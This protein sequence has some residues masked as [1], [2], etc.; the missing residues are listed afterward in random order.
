MEHGIV[1]TG[2]G[3]MLHGMDQL[4]SQE[5]GVPVVVAAEPELAVAAGQARLSMTEKN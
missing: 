1:L 5:L 4:F 2:G 3:S